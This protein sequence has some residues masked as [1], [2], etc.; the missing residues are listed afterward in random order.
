MDLHKRNRKLKPN[1]SP[2]PGN[3]AK[4]DGHAYGVV[5]HTRPPTQKSDSHNKIKHNKAQYGGEI[6]SN[7]RGK[8][9]SA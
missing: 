4:I 7:P 2:L 5:K 3:G 6:G 9:P 8:G 1:L